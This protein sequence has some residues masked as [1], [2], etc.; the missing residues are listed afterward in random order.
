M[1]AELGDTQDPTALVPGSPAAIHQTAQ[2][3]TTYG[4]AL[5]DAGQGLGS[6]DTTQG[7]VRPGV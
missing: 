3:L 5:H 6:I 1:T 4:D 2:N 7:V